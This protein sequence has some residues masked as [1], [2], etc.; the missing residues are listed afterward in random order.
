[1]EPRRKTNKKI[2]STNLPPEY[3][4]N[5]EELFNKA[6]QRQLKGRKVLVEGRMFP[7]ELILSVG[8]LPD[9]KGLRQVNFEA[10]I[11][12]S[13]KDVFEKLGV[14]V[15]AIS[16]LMDQYMESEEALELPLEWTAYDFEKTKVFLRTNGRNTQLES[17]AN[18]LLG[19]DTNEAFYSEGEDDTE[20]S[21]TM[22]EV[23]EKLK[24]KKPIH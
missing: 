15:D 18:K 6:F 1:M 10:S 5:I 22:K 9:P 3:L 8:Y 21:E 17:E 24:G 16:S 11:D 4:K 23:D 7:Q 20:F 12:H 13:A 14:A 2:R 19:T